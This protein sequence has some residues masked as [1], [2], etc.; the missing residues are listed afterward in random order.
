M[1][2]NVG[3]TSRLRSVL[4]KGLRLRP[5]RL[6]DAPQ[7]RRVLQENEDIRKFMGY[8]ALTSLQEAAR[9][10]R[11]VN[12]EEEADVARWWAI[13]DGDRLV[14]AVFFL[15]LELNPSRWGQKTGTLGYWLDQ[16]YR[17]KGVVTAAARSVLDFAFCGW[18]LHKVKIGHVKF[19]AASQAVIRKLGFRRIGIERREFHWHGKWMDH[20]IYELLRTQWKSMKRLRSR[21][22]LKRRSS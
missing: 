5:I 8:A 21:S 14:G 12:A 4:P 7:L 10:I 1:N 15:R 19:N 9:L 17:N 16:P 11:S 2:E 22:A 3:N 18:E 13:V 20:V 6:R